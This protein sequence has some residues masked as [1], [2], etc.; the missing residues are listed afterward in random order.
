M[1]NYN[2]LSQYLEKLKLNSFLKTYEK[3][4]DKNLN[5]LDLL[6]ELCRAEITLKDEVAKKNMVKTAGFPSVKTIEEFDFSFQPT[7]NKEKILYLSTLE[8]INQSENIIFTGS[9]GSGKSHLATALGVISA[10]NRVSTYFIKTQKLINTLKQAKDENRLEVRLK[11]LNR[12]KLLIID[13]FG[14]NSFTKEEAKLLFQLIELR[15]E[16]KSTIIT[17]NLTV[18]KWIDIFDDDILIAKAITDRLLHHC[19]LF[20]INGNSYRMK[21]L[22]EESESNQ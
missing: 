21:H 20:K 2:E 15:Y 4:I 18:D 3:L 8:F 1:L 13:E 12:Y 5:N 17:S 10:S 9:S 14:L 7:I 11:Q 22:F 6:T 16:K 19:T